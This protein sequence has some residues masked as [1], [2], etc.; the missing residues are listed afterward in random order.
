MT[1]HSGGSF[2]FSS[3]LMK[4]IQLLLVHH[5]DHDFENGRKELSNE[6]KTC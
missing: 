1:H 5:I 2:R 6:E 3:A 4:P